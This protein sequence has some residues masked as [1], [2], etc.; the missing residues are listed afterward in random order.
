MLRKLPFIIAFAGAALSATSASA[1]SVTFDP[2]ASL[3]LMGT[4][5][6]E[7]F[8]ALPVGSYGGGNKI[9]S[10]P[11]IPGI[12]AVP[13]FGSDGNYLAVQGN[14]TSTYLLT[15]NAATKF[16]FVLGSLDS[17]NKIVVNLLSGGSVVYQGLQIITGLASD[18]G[19]P[20]NGSQSDPSVNGRVLY[21][22]GGTDFIT[23]VAFT[24]IGS[25]AFEIDN[26]STAAPEPATWG[27]MIVA[28][29]MAGA[30]LRRRRNRSAI[31]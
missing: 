26:I 30:S 5:I 25:N 31:A 1:L 12:A 29:G 17:Y 8:N 21:D 16:S 7:T 15:T 18:F 11:S 4:T 19:L 9:V 27:M 6:Q 28:A 20:G 23:S 3:G 24:S 2:G 13:A 22:T 10:P 14:N